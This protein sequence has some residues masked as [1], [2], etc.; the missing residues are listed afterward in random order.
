MTWL[1]LLKAESRKLVTTRLL[2]GFLGTLVLFSSIVAVAV[3]LGSA[4]DDAVG[5]VDTAEAQRSLLAFGTNAMLFGGLFGATAVAR[6]YTH[7][8]V[9]PTYLLSPV[10]HRVQLAQLGAVLVAGGLL[11]AVG[12]G[13]TVA[14]GALSLPL[15]DQQLLLTAGAVAR[16]IAVAALA[17]A[18]GAIL[19]AG[20]GSLLRNTGGAVTAVV[21]LL[22]VG[23]PL[24]AQLLVE[25][26]PWVPSS[27]LGVLA[28]MDQGQAI[29]VSLAALLA[30]GLV[31]A[32]AGVAA[33]ERRDV[34]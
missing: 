27:L 25:V 24:V 22:L 29:G 19:G 8:T 31:P 21:L 7:G 11:G 1:R 6:E 10:R 28:G 18:T 2:W 33:I 32:I 20:I 12:G 13:L 14:A 9:V 26:A 15:V 23:P 34:I 3:V 17:G 5:F 4:T 30:W 16:L